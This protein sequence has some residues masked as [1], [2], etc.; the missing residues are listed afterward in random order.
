MINE[1]RTE[2]PFFKREDVHAKSEANAVI[3]RVSRSLD[4]VE[5]I[6]SSPTNPTEPASLEKSGVAGF[7]LFL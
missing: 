7:L 4:I 2:I 5:V 1:K 6:G 3:S